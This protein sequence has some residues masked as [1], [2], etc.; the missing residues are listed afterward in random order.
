MSLSIGSTL[1]GFTLISE[2]GKGTYGSVY[3]CE[4]NGERYAL[5]TTAL[6]QHPPKPGKKRVRNPDSSL[7]YQEYQML[8]NR[9]RWH[10]S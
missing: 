7:L 2:L 1:G 10:P 9:F 4:R 5:K 6:Y 8:V 3:M